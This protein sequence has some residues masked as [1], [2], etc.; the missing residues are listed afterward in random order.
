MLNQSA[1]Y[2]AYSICNT[3]SSSYQRYDVGVRE[4]K[5]WSWSLDLWQCN[6]LIKLQTTADQLSLVVKVNLRV[7]SWV[8]MHPSSN[9]PNTTPVRNA[10]ISA[11]ILNEPIS[12]ICSIW[13]PSCIS[14]GTIICAISLFGVFAPRPRKHFNINNMGLLLYR[15]I[16]CEAKICICEKSEHLFITPS[17]P[18]TEE[19]L[20]Q[21]I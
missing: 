19:S 18:W 3:W 2:N 16:A 9:A 17:A 8:A 13:Y 21:D 20:Q 1:I 6:H 7:Y 5:I 10:E 14:A 15:V 12:S 11:W 4:C